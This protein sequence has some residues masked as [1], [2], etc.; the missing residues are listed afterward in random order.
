[1]T[2]QET[3]EETTE[4]TTE[5]TTETEEQDP[6]VAKLRREAAGYRTKLREAEQ[7]RDETRTELD[8]LRGERQAEQITDALV[9]AAHKLGFKNPQGAA[10]KADA[11]GVKVNADGEVEGAEAALKALQEALP[12]LVASEPA[13]GNPPRRRGSAAAKE[14]DADRRKRLYGGGGDAFAGG[15]V[16]RPDA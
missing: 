7:E 9:D 11:A 4:Q 1:M 10:D 16:V 12:E 15:G 8:A 13:G 2:E 5:Q 3:T 14:S 6:Q